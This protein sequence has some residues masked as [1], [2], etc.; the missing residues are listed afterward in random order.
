MF[1][2]FWI[3]F[4]IGIYNFGGGYAMVTLIINLVVEKYQWITLSEFINF[5]TISQI[6]PGPIAINLATFIGYTMGN[7]IWGATLATIAVI[8]PSFI[9]ITAIVLFMKK[10]K[11][12]IHI[13]NF[14]IGI[15]PVVLG[16]IATSCISVIDAD[17]Y[18]LY[19]I[20]VFC[21]IFYLT[22]FKKLNPILAIFISGFIGMW[23]V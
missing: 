3:F 18:T 11:N 6:T 23:F 16:L 22:T 9:I 2:L 8:L 17:F 4:F 14:F 7:G 21:L 10:F 12:N 15:R 5:L 1:D 13:N 20:L 19:S